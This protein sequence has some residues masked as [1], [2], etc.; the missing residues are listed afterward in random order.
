MSK[1]AKK[2]DD[3]KRDRVKK[4]NVQSPGEAVKRPGLGG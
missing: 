2:G 1:K 4:P 3:G